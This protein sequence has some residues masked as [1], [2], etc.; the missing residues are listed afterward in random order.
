MPTV[1]LW[2]GREARALRRAL[3]LSVRAFAD[4][5][6]VATRTVSKWE[7]FGASIQPRPDTQAI[8]DIALERASAAE[9]E[10]FVMLLAD[11]GAPSHRA[12]TDTAPHPWDMETW[13]EDLERAVVMLAHQSFTA[14]TR[15]VS[16]WLTRH[17]AHVLDAKGLYLRARSLTLLGDARRD[18]GLLTGPRGA[19]ASYQ[20]ARQMF[21]DLAVP[22]RVAQIEL[23]L[24]VVKEMDGGLQS[25]AH[26]YTQLAEDERLSPRDRARARLWV[27]TAMSK[28][29]QH[30]YAAQVMRQAAQQFDDLDEAE[31]WAA[32]QQKLA[33][34]HRGAGDLANALHFIDAALVHGTDGTPM[35]RVRLSTAHAHIL[36]TDPATRDDGMRLLDRTAALAADTG[37]A[38]QLASI[39][40]IRHTAEPV[41]AH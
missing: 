31:D 7:Q 25:A 20:S 32:A 40:A 13:A 36:V 34:A 9:Q 39:Q 28:S 3:R 27:G 18:Q 6:G 14:A 2:T 5:L 17:P 21:T 41:G 38:H 22:R 35:Q 8:L 23:S 24:A 11:I 15:L 33:L 37:L 26:Q 30:T 4:H 1:R 29:G 16:R 12:E 19:L 10:R